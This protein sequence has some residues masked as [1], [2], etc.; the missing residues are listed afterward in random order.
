[1]FTDSPLPSLHVIAKKTQTNPKKQWVAWCGFIFKHAT[2]L[3]SEEAV[4]CGDPTFKP[5]GMSFHSPR[6][7]VQY[8]VHFSS[9]LYFVILWLKSLTQ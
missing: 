2:A 5:K 3:T 1:M 9:F 4:R 8:I 7:T 6:K